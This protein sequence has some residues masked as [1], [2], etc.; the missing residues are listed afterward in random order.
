MDLDTLAL[1]HLVGAAQGFFLALTL[2]VRQQ[3]TFANRLLGL[4][5]C[6]TLKADCGVLVGYRGVDGSTVLHCPEGVE[7]MTRDGSPC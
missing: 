1:I 7:A 4:W 3:N 5:M 2:A 6:D